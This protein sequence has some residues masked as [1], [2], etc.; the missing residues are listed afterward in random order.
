MTRRRKSRRAKPSFGPEARPGRAGIFG[1]A[2]I[3][4]HIGADLSRGFGR[5]I[6]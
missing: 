5:K 1:P 4:Y 6:F 2:I 3:L